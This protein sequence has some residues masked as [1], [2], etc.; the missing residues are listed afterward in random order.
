MY[1]FGTDNKFRLFLNRVITHRFFDPIV[2]IL[3]IFSTLTMTVD[4]PLNDPN[5][6]LSNILDY[7]DIVVTTL[8]TIETSLKIIVYGL[9][10][11]GKNSYLRN[12]WNIMD[13]FIVIFSVSLIHS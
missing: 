5:G 13:F 2:L 8:F 6:Q 4:N 7:I 12:S 3:I 9:L 10:L 11:N 1:L